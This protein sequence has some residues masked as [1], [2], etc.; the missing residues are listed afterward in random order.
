MNFGRHKGCSVFQS[1]RNSTSPDYEFPEKSY[2]CG[3]QQE[4]DRFGTNTTI[5]E[6]ET[7]VHTTS[8]E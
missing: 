2:R 5:E 3:C 8:F 4:L 1:V 7:H 6:H